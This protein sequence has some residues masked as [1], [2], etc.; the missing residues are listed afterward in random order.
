MSR[1]V[2]ILYKISLFG[3]ANH[4]STKIYFITTVHLLMDYS[5]FRDVICA[6]KYIEFR[7]IS[8]FCDVNSDRMSAL[9]LLY[10]LNWL[11]IYQRF[12]LNLLA[13][14]AESLWAYGRLLRYIQ[15]CFHV[16]FL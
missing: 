5:L 12:Y 4:I 6:C 15:V 8:H 11:S 13:C 7:I 9:P 1:D 10:K 2:I 3:G 14:F 16:S